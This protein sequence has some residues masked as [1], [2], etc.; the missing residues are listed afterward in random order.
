MVVAPL[1]SIQVPVG[2]D[3]TSHVEEEEA[4]TDCRCAL[5]VPT[6]RWEEGAWSGGGGRED[7][8]GLGM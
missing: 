2:S 7:G 3:N 5:P 1:Q 8:L 6:R 4:G